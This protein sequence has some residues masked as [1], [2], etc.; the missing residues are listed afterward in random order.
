MPAAP[1]PSA[2]AVGPNWRRCGRCGSRATGCSPIVS[3]RP[4]G[5][6][7]LIMRRGRVTAFIEVKA[8]RNADHGIEAVTPFQAR[9]ISAAARIWMAAR[10]PRIAGFLPF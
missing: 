9:R 1:A 10:S 2:R 4:H 5:E 7:D 3:K 8:R 6:V